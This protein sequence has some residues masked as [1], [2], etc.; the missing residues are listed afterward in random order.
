[1]IIVPVFGV[2]SQGSLSR[3]PPLYTVFQC[4]EKTGSKIFQSQDESFVYSLGIFFAAVVEKMRDYRISQEH[5]RMT[6]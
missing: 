1:M 2:P 3:E 6:N 5:L 4:E